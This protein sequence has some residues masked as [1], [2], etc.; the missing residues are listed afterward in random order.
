MNRVLGV[1]SV[2]ICSLCHLLFISYSYGSSPGGGS[3]GEGKFCDGWKNGNRPITGCLYGSLHGT[4]VGVLN[5]CLYG[6]AVLPLV[7]PVAFVVPRALAILFPV[8]LAINGYVNG[9]LAIYGYLAI[10]G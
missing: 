3:N 2:T 7:E 1:Y 10:N 5:G 9:C 8:A 4:R 6:L